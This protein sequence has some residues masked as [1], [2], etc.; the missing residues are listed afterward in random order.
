MK[1]TDL[2]LQEL[3]KQALGHYSCANIL[4]FLRSCSS[5]EEVLAHEQAS[6]WA[7]WYAENVIGG[8]WEEGEPI[9][10]TNSYYS[11]CY[12]RIFVKGRWVEAEPL[13]LT[14][15]YCAYWY[16]RDII[17]GRW[18]EAETIILTKSYLAEIYAHNIIKGPWE[19]NGKVYN[20]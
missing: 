5:I 9:I 10:L 20:G 6:E 17:K 13:M 3:I 12:A 14:D 8:R 2:N 18:A 1:L 15:P 16:A 11:Y 4:I 7:Y 19:V